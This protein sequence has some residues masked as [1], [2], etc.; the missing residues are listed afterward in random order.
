MQII[1]AP[2]AIESESFGIIEKYFGGKNIPSATRDIVRRVIHATADF[3]YLPGLVFHPKAVKAGIRAINAG[4]PIIVDVNM[5]KAGVNKNISAEF[6]VKVICSVDDKGVI[7]HSS[8]LGATRTALAMRRSAKLM[9]G[10]IVAVGNAPTA[11]FEICD[12]VESDLA[13]PALIIGVPVGFV[14]AVESKKKLRT[15]T[16]P[17][18]TNRSRR[19][20]SAVAVAITNALLILAKEALRSRA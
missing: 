12:L 14:G 11:L 18:I 13:K 4:K 9:D 20:G 16:V 2:K 7:R 3:N 6:G 17:Y 15:L 19:G 8:R 10:A 5:V 1:N